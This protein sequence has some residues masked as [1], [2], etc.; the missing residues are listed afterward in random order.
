MARKQRDIFIKPWIVAA[1]K[2]HGVFLIADDKTVDFLD[3][4]TG[5]SLG[6]W[7]TSTNPYFWL[8][9]VSHPGS[10]VDA[11]K[12]I[13]APYDLFDNNFC[14]ASQPAKTQEADGSRT[15]SGKAPRLHATGESPNG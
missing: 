5:K 14:A 4:N 1:A 2:R 11:L 3:V 6:R 7:H 15:T 9:D 13:I 8:N 10:I 12:A